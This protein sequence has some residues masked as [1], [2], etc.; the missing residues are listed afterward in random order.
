MNT[1]A[2]TN[3]VGVPSRVLVCSPRTAGWHAPDADWDG[4][5]FLRSPDPERAQAAHEQL[6]AVLTEQGIDVLELGEAPGLDSVYTHDPSLALGRGVILLP[7]G[8]A[9]RRE[10]CAAQEAAFH[11]AGVEILARLEAPATAEGG[12][13]VWLNEQCLMVGRS[14]RTNAEAVRQL[15]AILEPSAIEVVEIPLVHWDGPDRCLHLMSLMSMLDERTV[16]IDRALLC[17]STLE[18]LESRG[19]KLLDI[20]PDENS[21]QAANVLALGERRVL[22]LKENRATNEIMQEAGFEVVSIPGRDLCLPGQGGPTCLTRPLERS[23]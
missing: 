15:R 22:S 7:M 10:E 23:A 5:G 19:M 13:L 14:Y 1:L 4:Y 17:V 21:T 16:L 18:F 9:Q 2:G 8:K 3:M 12:D 6:C 11:G 20:Q